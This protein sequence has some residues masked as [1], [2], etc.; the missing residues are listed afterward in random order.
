MMMHPYG[1]SYLETRILSATPLELVGLLYEGAIDAVRDARHHLASGNIRERARCV[2]KALEIVGELASSLDRTAGGKIGDGLSALYDF[3]QQSL[4]DANFRQDDEGLR[5][6]E[7]LLV[8]LH[9]A[10][11]EVI[12]NSPAAAVPEMA[13][14]YSA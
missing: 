4:M 9:E 14:R 3:I 6:A 12:A 10:W 1:S 11:S 13:Y 8:T 2:T 7:S 5:N